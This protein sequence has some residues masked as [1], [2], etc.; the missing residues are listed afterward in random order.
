MLRALIPERP[1]SYISSV[2]INLRMNFF[3]EHKKEK[4]EIREEKNE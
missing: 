3:I 1:N 4:H 2:F